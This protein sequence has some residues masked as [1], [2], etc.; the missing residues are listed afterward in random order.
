ML[1]INVTLNFKIWKLFILAPPPLIIILEIETDDNT[2]DETVSHE[3]VEYVCQKNRSNER[4]R[5]PRIENSI[6]I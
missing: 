3:E 6:Y 4:D 2:N 5:K 1:D